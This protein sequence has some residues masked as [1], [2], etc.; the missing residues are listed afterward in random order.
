MNDTEASTAPEPDESADMFEDAGQRVVD[1]FL[2]REPNRALDPTAVIGIIRMIMELMAEC[3]ERRAAGS[4]ERL[5]KS[6]R[7]FVKA[8]VQIK[9]RRQMIDDAVARGGTIRDGRREYRAYGQ[10][11]AFSML[12]AA[13]E[14][15]D[16]EITKLVVNL[17]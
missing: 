3:R 11:V 6:G 10:S 15:S 7:R 16:N 5:A 2:I 8:T 13:E 14:S 12:D 1:K 9:V 4:I 17:P